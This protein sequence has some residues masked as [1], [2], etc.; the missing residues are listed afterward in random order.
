MKELINN[1]GLYAFARLIIVGP[2]A[3]AW[4]V[5]EETWHHDVRPWLAKQLTHYGQRLA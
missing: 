3:L 4:H 5:G 1:G 2:Y